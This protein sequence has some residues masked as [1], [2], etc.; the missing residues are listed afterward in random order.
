M[1]K[2]IQRLLLFV[3]TLPL[4]MVVMVF[5]P[6]RNHLAAN[7]IVVV[8]SALGAVEFAAMMS[9]KT[10]GVSPREAGILGSL[11]PAAMTM[12]MSFDLNFYVFPGV[13]MAGFSWLLLS[14]IFSPPDKFAGSLDH[15]ISGF[16]VII[17]PG[18]FMSWII[19][20]VQ[21]FH[22]DLVILGFF[23]MVVA[24]DSG[25]W[26]LGMLLGGNNRGILPASPNKSVAGF[27]GGFAGSILIGLGAVRFFPVAFTSQIMPS[28]WA[29]IILGFLSAGA[30]SL[31]DLAESVMKRSSAIKDSGGLVPGRGGILDSIDSLA[32][33]APVYYGLYRFFFMRTL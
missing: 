29:G 25:A 2:L 24:C 13:L 31:G 18:L 6:Y 17:Y 32:M 27:I 20:M 5:L 8:L 4:I 7:L 33:A 23:L 3:I 14:R 30:A 26:A 12:T 16:A 22:A 11:G 1:K 21:F 10:G 28:P 15:I 19:L 9:K